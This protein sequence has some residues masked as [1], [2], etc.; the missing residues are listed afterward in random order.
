MGWDSQFQRNT[1]SGYSFLLPEY[2]RFTTGISWLTTYRPDNTLSVSGGVR[3][4]YGRMRVF[5][6]DDPYLATYLQEQGYDE[7]QVE[8]Y[9]W[10]SRRVNRSFGDYSLS[11]GVVWTP[12]MR[13][14]LK[15]N[16]GR[17]FRLPGANE[18]A[19]NGVHHGTF[20]HEQ[21]DATLSSEQGWQMDASYQL[22]YGR[23]SVYVSPFQSTYTNL[24]KGHYVFKV[25]S[26]NSD[27]IWTE[28]TRTLDI[29]IL[30]SFWET[31]FA[32]FLY[33]LFFIMIIVAAVYILFTIYRLKHE[34]SVEQ[35]MTDM[36]LRFFTDISHELRTPLTLISG[37]V[38]YILGNTKLPDD[39]REQLISIYVM[40]AVHE[41]YQ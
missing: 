24:P 38:E 1:I 10:N 13:H 19:S 28:N 32:Y 17:S 7:E 3:Y 37:P 22:K 34:V 41:R 11:L 20:R 26:T 5:A 25:R 33:V 15:V 21:G 29:E 40:H 14:Q 31:P 2:D 35:Q 30:P 16:V 23:W 39:A 9:R 36:K 8:F 6:H 18:L 12:S 27:G 4:D